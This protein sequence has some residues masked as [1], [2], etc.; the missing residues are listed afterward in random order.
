VVEVAPIGRAHDHLIRRTYYNEHT[1][2]DVSF[3]LESP[4]FHFSEPYQLQ[5]L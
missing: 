4:I 1:I 2:R 5:N 3:I